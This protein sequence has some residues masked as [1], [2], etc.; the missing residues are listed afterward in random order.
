MKMVLNC[1]NERTSFWFVEDPFQ[2]VR[3]DQAEKFTWKT[4]R[5]KE[6]KI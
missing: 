3:T 1:A 5:G 2:V 4:K 6:K